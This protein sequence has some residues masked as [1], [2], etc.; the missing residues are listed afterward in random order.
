MAFGSGQPSASHAP[1]GL[2]PSGFV[3]A[4]GCH[5]GSR[6][7]RPEAEQWRLPPRRPVDCPPEVARARQKAG[8]C[9]FVIFM[10][11]TFVV[12]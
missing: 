5:C 10:L 1:T 3:W 11:Y 6:S 8:G 12:P 7:S 2:S 4:P 9:I